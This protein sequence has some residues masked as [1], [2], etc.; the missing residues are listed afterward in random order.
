MVDCRYFINLKIAI[1]SQCLCDPFQ[2][3]TRSSDR[4][5]CYVS[6]FCHVSRAM[7]LAKFS[8]CKSDRQGHW[9]WCHSI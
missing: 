1:S 8:N 4:A 3:W 2:N 7:G 5:T 9:H 6:K